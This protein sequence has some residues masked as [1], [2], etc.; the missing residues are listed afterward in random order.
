MESGITRRQAVGVA[1][2]ALVAGGALAQPGRQDAAAL[3]TLLQ[4]SADADE[5]RL[6]L[7]AAPRAIPFVDPLSDAYASALSADQRRNLAGLASIRRDALSVG[8]RIAYDVLGYQARQTIASFESGVFETARR[9]PL[10]PSFGLH[11]EMADFVSGAA[12]FATIADYEAGLRRLDGF[13]GYMHSVVDRLKEG[14]ANG[15]V[16]PA[17]IVANVLAEVD[18]MLALPIEDSPFYTAIKAAPPTIDA[19]AHRRL[20]AAYRQLIAMRVYPAYRL[21]KEFLTDTYAPRAGTAPGRWAMKGGDALYAAELERHT[22]TTMTADALHDLGVAE[23][24]RIRQ[25][26]EAAR[27]ATGFTG[28]LKA[29]FNYI[30]VDKRFYCK[31]PEELL[32]RFAA[33]EARIWKSIPK[34]FSRRPKAPFSVQALP[35]LGAQRGTGYY[36][37]GP[38]DGKTPGVLYFNMAMLGTRPIPTLE[39]LTLHEGIPGHHF[40]ITLARENDKLPPLLRLHGDEHFTAFTEGWGLYA[41]SLGRDLGMFEDPYQWFGHLDMEMLRAVRLVVDTGLHAQRWDRQRAIDYMLTNTSMAQHDVE[42][43]I[44]RYIA[45]PGQA[46]AYKTGELRF[47]ALRAKAEKGLGSAYTIRDFH[48][49]V[50]GTGALPLQVLEAKIDHWIAAGGGSD[51]S[52]F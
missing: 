17:I 8:D 11:V 48:D 2:I 52:G 46:C 12:P 40:Q 13:A 49:Q 44:D 29:F 51:G 20:A 9:A 19:S 7:S 22:T 30:R 23:V 36:R 15:Q 47:Q 3:R 21:W 25:E 38:P 10:D 24:T 18:A 32:A 43:E 16:Q 28:D 6:P 50:L 34:L 33:I 45:A 31:T 14:L 42:V 4:A 35:V 26:M 1:G 5:R 41:E 27:V 37:P 39:T